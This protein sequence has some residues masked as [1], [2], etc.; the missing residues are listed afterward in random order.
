M[1]ELVVD[2][3]FGTYRLPCLFCTLFQDDEDIEQMIEDNPQVVPYLLVIKSRETM[4]YCVVVEKQ[5]FMEP[6][7]FSHAFVALV[8]AYYVF[9]ISYSKGAYS[10]CIMIQR[11]IFGISD[12]QPI[13]KNVREAVTTMK[14]ILSD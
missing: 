13:P 3:N 9:N 8:A 4:S 14:N 1:S 10:P 5:P 7:T 12:E 6:S 11:Y 2:F